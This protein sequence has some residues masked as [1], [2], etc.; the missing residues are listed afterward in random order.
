MEEDGSE[1]DSKGRLIG[2][3]LQKCAANGV[4]SIDSDTK[5]YYVDDPWVCA[6]A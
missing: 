4:C 1:Y 5:K 2:Y 6:V 3:E